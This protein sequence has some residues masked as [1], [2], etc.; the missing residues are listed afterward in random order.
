MNKNEA[1]I[2]PNSAAQN[3][4][5]AAFMSFLPDVDIIDHT[6]ESCL[7]CGTILPLGH[8]GG[9][10]ISPTMF[11]A[12]ANLKIDRGPPLCDKR[13]HRCTEDSPWPR[14]RLNS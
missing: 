3:S 4:T 7:E 6:I 5:A 1:G 9:K 11:H 13:G 14:Q 8:K 2:H 12:W 10:L